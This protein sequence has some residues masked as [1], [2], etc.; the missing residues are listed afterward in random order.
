MSTLVAL[1][2]HRWSAPVLAELHRQRGSR[3]VTLS[4]MLGVSRESLRQTL[5]ALIASGQV[6][7]NPGY[8]HPLRPEYVLTSHGRPLGAACA[9]LVEALRDSRLEEIAFRKWSLP[10]VF[11]LRAGPLRYSELRERLPGISG[12]AL[13]LSLKELAAA[14]LVERTVVEGYPPSTLYGVTERGGTL[15]PLIARLAR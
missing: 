12:R 1:F 8:G 5:R 4:R 6:A 9:Q 15:V 10:V 3:F 13:T 14:D 2:H 7:R 11:A